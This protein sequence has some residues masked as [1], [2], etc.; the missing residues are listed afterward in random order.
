MTT[1]VLLA[2]GLA[3]F[4]ILA[5]LVF[6]RRRTWGWRAFFLIVLLPVAAGATLAG[7]LHFTADQGVAPSEE[8]RTL[9]A[10]V[11]YQRTV[12]VSPLPQV[13]HVVRV[14]LGAKGLSFLV[15]PGDA[16]KL[17]PLQAKTATEFVTEHKLEL[18]IVSGQFSPGY[19]K[20]PWDEPLGPNSYVRPNGRTVSR[21]VECGK[22]DQPSTLYFTDK[23]EASIGRAPTNVYNALTGDCVLLGDKQNAAACPFAGDRIARSA[24][25]LDAGSKTLFLV[26]VDGHRKNV[27]SGVNAVE[28][29]EILQGLG[30]TQAVQLGAGPQ[31][32][33]AWRNEEGEATPLSIPMGAGTAGSERR[34]GAVLGVQAASRITV[35]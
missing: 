3:T 31:A 18:A 10:G 29:G 11:Q 1:Y 12:A 22:S 15:T 24:A 28:L 2:V 5:R 21:T 6:D 8:Q 16:G 26:V 9:F 35:P 17:L 23:N 32:E 20:T 4:A 7:A 13:T 14:D 25:G 30:V 27:A 33:L 19:A 34:V